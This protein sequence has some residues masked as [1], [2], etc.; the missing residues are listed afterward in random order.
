MAWPTSWGGLG[1]VDAHG[2]QGVCARLAL[3]VHAWDG[4]GLLSGPCL[5][6]A[7]AQPLPVVPRAA[8][9]PACMQAAT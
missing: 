6:P 9:I 8:V 3:Q 2:G 5:R 1:L 4:A 7:A